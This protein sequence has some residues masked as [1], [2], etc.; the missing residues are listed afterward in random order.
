M[1]IE[2]LNGPTILAGES[3]SDSVDC[4]GGRIIKITMPTGWNNA[5]LTFLTSS[6]DVGYNDIMRPDGAEVKCVV[7]AGTAIVGLELITGFIK[8]RSGSREHGVPQSEQRTFAI[9]VLR[10]PVIT[11]SY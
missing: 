1:P 4:R 8:F 10:P 11:Q 5:D 2:V 9:A 7:T 3:L 6:D